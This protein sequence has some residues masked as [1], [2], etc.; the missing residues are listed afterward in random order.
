[1]SHQSLPIRLVASSALSSRHWGPLAAGHAIISPAGE[2]LI[3]HSRK[4]T[5]MTNALIRHLIASGLN[6]QQATSVTA[7][8]L[9]KLFMPKDGNMLLEEARR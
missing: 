9:V 4:K 1:M 8:T 7:E 5:I 3:I 6:K 2:G